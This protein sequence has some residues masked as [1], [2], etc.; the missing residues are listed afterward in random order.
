MLLYQLII[1][2]LKWNLK[3]KWAQYKKKT[4]RAPR[5]NENLVA[6]TLMINN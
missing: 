2:V 1:L 6:S 5:E 3:I 4:S